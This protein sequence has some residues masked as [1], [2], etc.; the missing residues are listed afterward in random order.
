MAPVTT[1]S[2]SEGTMR[3]KIILVLATAALAACSSANAPDDSTDG[4]AP[5]VVSTVP[6]GP[7][8]SPQG[9]G[10]SDG[11]PAVPTD[12]VI[13]PCLENLRLA[14]DLLPGPGTCRR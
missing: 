11:G 8:V 6:D 1:I 2:P 7:S 5:D 14:S 4:L 13:P 3:A 10:G 9:A 12:G